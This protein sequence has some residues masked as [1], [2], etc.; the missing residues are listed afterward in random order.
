MEFT[1][2]TTTGLPPSPRTWHAVAVLPE[3]RIFIH[4]GYDGN[5]ILKDS[6]IFELGEFCCSAGSKINF[7]RQVPTGDWNYSSQTR[8]SGRQCKMFRRIGDPESAISGPA[9]YNYSY[10]YTTDSTN[11]LLTYSPNNYF[12]LT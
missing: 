4:G 7:F 3:Q 8:N 9:L 12:D 2:P 11:S 5:Q 1:S 6:F 10:S